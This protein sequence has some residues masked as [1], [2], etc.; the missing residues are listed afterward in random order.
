MPSPDTIAN[1]A[2]SIGLLSP[3]VAIMIPN[4]KWL[5]RLFLVATAF[6]GLAICIIGEAVDAEAAKPK[7]NLDVQ[8]GYAINFWTVIVGGSLFT[9]SFAMKA[10]WLH[11]RRGKPELRS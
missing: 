8:L 11:F 7:E 6:I 10:A 9:A 3:V 4:S 5:F 2:L 1:L